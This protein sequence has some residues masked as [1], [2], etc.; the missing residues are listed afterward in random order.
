[1]LGRMRAE[2]EAVFTPTVLPKSL[3]ESLGRV[4]KNRD[5]VLRD[6]FTEKL[7]TLR[8]RYQYQRYVSGGN[9][10]TKRYESDPEERKQAR[11]ARKR[12][13]QH[14]ADNLHRNTWLQWQSAK[15][16]KA[17]LEHVRSAKIDAKVPDEQA[18]RFAASA[19]EDFGY[20]LQD[21]PVLRKVAHSY[22]VPGRLIGIGQYAAA[23]PSSLL[24]QE[25]VTFLLVQREQERREALW[26]GNL[27]CY[28]DPEFGGYRRTADDQHDEQINDALIS[29][30]Q[31][32]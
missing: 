28:E 25:P 29:S 24:A 13:T 30:W 11:L 17:S 23:H 27:E 3:A 18:L 2:N 22:Y 20:C 7:P 19:I 15:L 12:Q 6:Q 10:H 5:E 16:F 1:M 21:K 26:G 8:D 31:L 14:V 4:L 32:K 9:R